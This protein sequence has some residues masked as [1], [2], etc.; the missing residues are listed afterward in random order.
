MRLLLDE[1]VDERIRHAFLDH[2]CLSA[3]YAGLNGLKNGA[4]LLAAENAGFDVIVTTDRG[5]AGQQNLRG[6]RLSI[7]ILRAATNRLKDLQA[8]MPSALSALSSIERGQIITVDAE[9]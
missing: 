6:R 5:M 4:L 3:R 8:L 7:L 2:E 1:C 9:H